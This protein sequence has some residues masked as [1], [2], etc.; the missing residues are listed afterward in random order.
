MN[1]STAGPAQHLDGA[2]MRGEIVRTYTEDSLNLQGMLCAPQSVTHRLA[3]HIHGSYGNFYENLFLD[4]LSEAYTSSGTAFLPV[5]TRGHDYYADFKMKRPESG[6]DSKRIGGIL[7]HFDQCLLDIRAWIDF[8]Q[9]QGF[10]TIILQGHSL[11][12]MKAAYYCARAKDTRVTALFLISPPDLVGTVR[13]SCNPDIS[14]N[15]AL[16][17]G[18]AQQNPDLLMPD[19]TSYDPISAGNYLSIYDNPEIAGLFNFPGEPNSILGS[20]A[21]PVHAVIGEKD[22]YITRDAEELMG[23]LGQSVKSAPRFAGKV[24]R[25]ANHVYDDREKELG[26]VLA[27]WAS[28]Y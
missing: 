12:A 6:Y 23:L 4:N 15:L 9:S 25:D 2:K 18:L 24:V 17:R 1:D 13:K 27:D 26:S 22:E 3:L 10:T 16:A 28:R 20:L 8:A 19:G 7:E 21:L 14:R 11:G 5:N